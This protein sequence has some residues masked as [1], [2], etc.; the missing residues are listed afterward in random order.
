MTREEALALQQA[1]DD[2]LE[3]LMRDPDIT[4]AAVNWGDLRCSDVMQSLLTGAI[5][6][7]VE[8]V[9]PDAVDFQLKLAV[10]LHERGHLVT[11]QTEW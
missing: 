1:A 11:V 8:E 9:S 10:M 3:E 7:L 2:A 4:L 6:V 5:T